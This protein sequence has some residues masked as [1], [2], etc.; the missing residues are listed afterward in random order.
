MVAPVERFM[1][2]R[3][4]SDS[5]DLTQ[6]FVSRGPFITPLSPGHLNDVS[7]LQSGDLLF[8]TAHSVSLELCAPA[9]DS[10]DQSAEDME[11]ADLLGMTQTELAVPPLTP[12]RTSTPP[13]GI[14]S[15]NAKR[16]SQPAVP[17]CA[18]GR[19]PSANPKP[20]AHGAAAT[21]NALIDEL[22][23]AYRF[24][25]DEV[26]ERLAQFSGDIKRTRAFLARCRRIVED[27]C[28]EET[29]MK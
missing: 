11:V 9:A 18:H 26:A 1:V 16:Q 6:Y 20:K 27:I 14:R 17:A 21:A 25:P 4:G 10:D 15:K 19:S 23:A 13:T 2:R 29:Q 7:A 24:T 22:S 8:S 12:S 5:L 3:R 28:I